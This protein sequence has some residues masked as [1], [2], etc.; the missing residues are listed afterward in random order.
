M[1]ESTEETEFSFVDDQENDQI[2]PDLEMQQRSTRVCPSN[3][4]NIPIRTRYG[5]YSKPPNRLGYV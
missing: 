2:N 5:R 3:E 1:G 4:H